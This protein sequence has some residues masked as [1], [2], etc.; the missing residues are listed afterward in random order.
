MRRGLELKWPSSL[1]HPQVQQVWDDLTRAASGARRVFGSS[2][3]KFFPPKGRMQIVGGSSAASTEVR[4]VQAASYPRGNLWNV[5]RGTW[6]AREGSS[7]NSCCVQPTLLALSSP[8]ATQEQR[9]C[10]HTTEPTWPQLPASLSQ[11]HWS[12]SWTPKGGREILP[13][14]W[15]V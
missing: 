3:K 7:A 2:Q 6:A 9:L 11:G 12:P 1:L 4:P 8:P 13:M 5:R 10:F 14:L 15:G